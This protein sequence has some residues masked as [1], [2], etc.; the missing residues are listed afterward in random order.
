[1][2]QVHNTCIVGAGFISLF[3]VEAIRATR[4]ARLVAIC[5][6]DGD[7]AVSAARKYGVDKTFSS[8]QEL[9]DSG[10][11]D[12]AHVLVPAD[13][14]RAVAEPLLRAGINVFL[15]KPLAITSEDCEALIRAAAASGATLGVNHNSTF[16]PAYLDLKNAIHSGRIGKLKHVTSHLN[17]P[18]RQ[19]AAKQF[20]HWMFQLPQNIFL[21]LG[22][23]PLSQ[24]FDLVGKPMQ[25]STLTSGKHILAPGVEVF[26]TWQVSLVCERGTAQLLLS[27]GQDFPSWQMTAIC[28]DG[29]VSGDFLHERCTVQTRSKDMDFANS[30]KSGLSV[31]GQTAGQSIA[32]A[33]GYIGS[34][35]KLIP[36]SDPFIASIRNAVAAFYQ[37]LDKT[38]P[39]TD[40]QAG[41]EVMRMCEQVTAS[42]SRSVTD[43]AP[44]AVSSTATAVDALVIG[45]TGFIGSALVR[46]MLDAGLRIRV[47]ARNTRT[48]PEIFHHPNVEL[49]RASITDAEGLDRAIAGAE[50]VIHL[51]HGGGGDTW[52]AIQKSMVDG[53]R[54]I[55]EA[56]LRHKVK[57]LVYAGTLASL[58]L[59]DS[60]EVITGATGS[61]PQAETRGLY[62]RAK[63]ACDALLEDMHRERGLPAVI[64]RPGVVI[65]AGGTIMHSG[66][67]FFNQ[68][69][70]MIGWN[71]GRNPLPFVLVE[72]CASAVFKAMTSPA[73]VGKAYNVVGD[74]RLS[75][76]EYMDELRLATGRPFR[77]YPQSVLKLQLIEI[78]KWVI[79]RLTGRKD[80]AFPSYR[81]LKSRGMVSRFDTSD[82]K[83]DLGWQPE[84]DRQ[85][86]IERGIAVHRKA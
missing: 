21:E 67:G 73:A 74:V 55:A 47:L 17:I 61:D 6:P 70:H 65:G 80:A 7:R 36:S 37:G 34:Q 40:G 2:N 44:A 71:S 33:L 11:C 72:D 50:N 59:G 23:H 18:L 29:T 24:L 64:L 68:D 69:A 16:R 84:S 39:F 78:G 82:I 3:H 14:H 35:L 27:V 60:G 5:E 15:E 76:R 25:V 19:L 52:A 81:D 10:S 1:M 4:N 56:C 83:G 48:L 57:R 51:A 26:D 32:G 9:I 75:A 62:S 42:V 77:F 63:A 49:M 66:I 13:H 8:I 28:E 54:L 30:L 38:T 20:G 58:Y 12:T 79:K 31:A 41:Y 46:Q 85:R 86:F 45:G 22:V 53:T 43:S